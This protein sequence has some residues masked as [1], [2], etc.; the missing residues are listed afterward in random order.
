MQYV[1]QGKKSTD[2]FPFRFGGNEQSFLT[3]LT[4]FADEIKFVDE[5]NKVSEQ[6]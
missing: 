6:R 5:I 1:F 2:L 4:K 3:E